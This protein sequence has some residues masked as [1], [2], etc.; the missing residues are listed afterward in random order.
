MSR[1]ADIDRWWD[2]AA[3]LRADPELF[4]PVSGRGLSQLQTALAKSVCN[5]CQVLRQ[6]REYA[7][8][9]RQRYG[10]WGGLD[11]DER[12]DLL[13]ARAAH[14]RALRRAS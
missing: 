7:L 8:A 10:V 11:E 12:S 2:R 5:S 14:D 13:K 4:F 3:C 1:A 9:T 6:C